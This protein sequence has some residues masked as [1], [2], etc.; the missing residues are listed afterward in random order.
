MSLLEDQG[1][2]WGGSF[3]NK[4]RK[5]EEALTLKFNT[6]TEP[7]VKTEYDMEPTDRVNRYNM[8]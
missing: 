4:K 1:S 5:K 6:A 3:L 8:T 2:P 7:F